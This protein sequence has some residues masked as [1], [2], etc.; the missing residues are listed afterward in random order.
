MLFKVDDEV[1]DLFPGLYLPVAVARGVDNRGE[2]EEVTAFLKQT[3][4]GLRES[5]DYP[6]AQSHP[7]ICLWREA[8]RH[9][10]ISGKR[11]RSSVEAL[12][13]RALKDDHPFSI[14][15]L[16]DCYNAI[17]LKHLVPA[18]AFDLGAIT[19]DLTLRRTQEG[20]RFQEIGREPVPVAAGEVAYADAETILTRHF[21]WRQAE[22]GKITSATD[23]IFLVAEVLGEV[24][25][26]V[27]QAVACDF[28]EV[29]VRFFGLQP[30]VFLVDQDRPQ[31]EF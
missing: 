14:N 31:I 1:F 3:W 8:F 27:A 25:T 10:G 30:Q 18:G 29:L 9:M 28:G 24:G 16:V 22:K 5:F 12:V 6:N 23:Y 7:R 26:E 19:G 20:E 13:R 2:R 4:Q 17:S 11:F 15:P 21:V